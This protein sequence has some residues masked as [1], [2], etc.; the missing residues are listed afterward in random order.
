MR[1]ARSF[2]ISYLG[3]YVRSSLFLYLYEVFEGEREGKLFQKGSPRTFAPKKSGRCFSTAPPYK[4]N[5]HIPF[6]MV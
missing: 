5:C 6:G 1:L 4:H 2:S 3:E